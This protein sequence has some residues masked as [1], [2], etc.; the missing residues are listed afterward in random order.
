M[1]DT[2]NKEPTATGEDYN[3]WATPENMYGTGYAKET[4]DNERQDY[5]NF[6]ADTESLEDAIPDGATI[7]GIEI[8]SRGFCDDTG[9]GVEISLSWDGGANLIAFK[10][11]FFITSL[12]TQTWGGSTDNWGR[13]WSKSEFSNANFRVVLTYDENTPGSEI[14]LDWL[15]V[16]VYYTEAPVGT[17]IK[18]NIADDFKDVIEIKI[19]FGDVW[20]D[21]AEVKQNIGDAWKVVY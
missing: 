20:K 13:S 4:S 18:I 21:V 6:I 15:K 17:N 8:Q 7:D 5:Y 19:N 14:N 10:R 16:K 1:A 11:E 3:Q 2:G 9:D 12:T